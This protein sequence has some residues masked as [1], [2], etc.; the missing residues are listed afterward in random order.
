ME[1]SIA[2][3]LAYLVRERGASPHTVQAYGTD[4][5]QFL[6]HLQR[7]TGA[8]DGGPPGGVDHR[9][10]RRFLAELAGDGVGASSRARKLATLRSLFRFLVREGRVEANPA[11]LVAAP[12]VSKNLPR[13][14][15]IDEVLRLLSV[16]SPDTPT[17]RRDRALLET[18]YG[19]GLRIA[20]IAGLNEGDLQAD[21]TLVRV[22]G[23]GNK[24]RIVPIVHRARLALVAYL[25]DPDRPLPVP[26][27]GGRPLFLTPGGD[28]FTPRRLHD[29]V[30]GLLRAAGLPSS[31][32]A[33]AL[34][35]TYATHLLEGGADLRSIQ[36][37]LGHASLS[38]TQRYTHVDLQ[39]MLDAYDRA[40]PRAK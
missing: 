35:H 29:V 9:T 28:R 25:A 19:C 27:T 8:V 24:E 20:E 2:D 13:V 17:G 15:T 32:S 18:F 30:K 31:T 22:R 14:L 21:A 38:T 5:R 26:E 4:L 37:L 34:R 6:G 11:R 33:H 16:P 40:H 7:A 39:K 23:K 1:Q 36:E 10:V 12:R 3:F